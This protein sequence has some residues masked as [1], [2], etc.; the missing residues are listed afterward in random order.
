MQHLSA[1]HSAFGYR[2]GLTHEEYNDTPAA[3]SSNR[4]PRSNFEL[5]GGEDAFVE[6]Q[7]SD[8]DGG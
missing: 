7:D 1:W 8:L 2:L 4:G 5:I 3:N 6:E